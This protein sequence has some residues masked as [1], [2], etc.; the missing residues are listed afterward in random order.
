MFG[1]FVVEDIGP[2]TAGA[3]LVRALLS[4]THEVSMHSYG[5]R[6]VDLGLAKA[7]QTMAGIDGQHV[8]RL[9]TDARYQ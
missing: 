5:I 7:T 6:L 8:T 4:C 9:H 1:R 3:L 2:W